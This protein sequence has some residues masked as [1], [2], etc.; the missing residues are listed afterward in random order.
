MD[1][2][3]TTKD[4]HLIK[5]KVHKEDYYYIQSRIIPHAL[6][7]LPSLPNIF[8]E[9]QN[10]IEHIKKLLYSSSP[11]VLSNKDAGIGTTS[12]AAKYIHCFHDEYKHIA[13]VHCTK[14]ISTSILSLSR[15]LGIEF[16]E[17][18]EEKTR[19]KY[20]LKMMTSSLEK[21]SLLIID[22]VNDYEDLENNYNKIKACSNM[23]IL[24]TTCLTNSQF[25]NCYNIKQFDEEQ[26]FS[27]FTKYYPMHKDTDNDLFSQIYRAVGGNTQIILMLAKNLNILQKNNE[28]YSLSNLFDAFQK[29]GLFLPDKE[30]ITGNEYHTKDVH[31]KLPTD[32]LNALLDYVEL[33]EPEKEILSVFAVLPSVAILQQNLLDLLSQ[34]KDIKQNLSLLAQ[35]GWID[36]DKE[37]NTYFC[38]T[39][40]QDTIKNSKRV[41]DLLDDCNILIESLISYLEYEPGTGHLTK[42]SYDRAAIFVQYAESISRFFYNQEK[43]ISVLYERIGRYYATTGNLSKALKYYEECTNLKKKLYEQ[44]PS[45]TGFKFGLAISYSQLGTIYKNIGDIN[46]TLICFQEDTRLTKELYE[47]Y[48]NNIALKNGLAMSYSQLATTYQNTNNSSKV[49]KYFEQYTQLKKELFEE[50]PNNIGFKNGL[51]ISYSKLG[52]AYMDNGKLNKALEC[53]KEEVKL[54]SELYEIN[55]TNIRIKNALAISYSKLGLTYKSM[56]NFE[57]ALKYFLQD[58]KITRELFIDNPGNVGFKNGLAVSCSKLG[59]MYKN[60]GDLSTALKYY[61][62]YSKLKKELYQECPDFVGFKNG[63]AISYS[64]LGS[65]YKNMGN[66][67]EALKYYEL[68]IHLKKELHEEYPNNI[69]L[70]NSLAIAYYK[71]GMFY[72]DYMK[73]KKKAYNYLYRSEKLLVELLREIPHSAIFSSFLDQ[74]DKKIKSL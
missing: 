58:T 29:K 45:N 12:V 18:M 53:F 62:E 64:K 31:D 67:N 34:E 60:R 24:I 32:I 44:Y 61:E 30:I 39:I 2:T 40:V 6:T 66:L 5:D 23:H 72:K 56:N 27:L 10:E 74:V 15:V 51:A 55:P 35:K 57:K 69:G 19:L 70:K 9:R 63:L 25:Y 13:W 50:Y 73:S 59:S 43:S 46:K 4:N 65:T 33:T 3:Y 20:I 38:N 16:D 37:S 71:I 36:F 52:T 21:P 7:K 11:L 22:G 41:I 42:I 17:K 47:E 68:Y 28:M 8:L 1:K 26:I 54:F 14:N 49:L 48:P